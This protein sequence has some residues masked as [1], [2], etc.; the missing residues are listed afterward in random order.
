MKI[1]DRFDE[2]FSALNS[3]SS[4]IWPLSAGERGIIKCWL[5]RQPENSRMF[6][7]EEVEK[8]AGQGLLEMIF[9]F[10]KGSE[11]SFTDWWHKKKQELE[12]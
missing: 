4:E 7:L 12:K 10:N 2:T 3:W 9:A 11:F 1:A 5:S 6:T 8:I